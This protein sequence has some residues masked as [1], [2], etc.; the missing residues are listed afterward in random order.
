[1]LTQ[2]ASALPSPQNVNGATT[3]W[4]QC[5]LTSPSPYTTGPFIKTYVSGMQ[6]HGCV[7]NKSIWNYIWN[8][9]ICRCVKT[10]HYV[11][12]LWLS[13]TTTLRLFKSP[14]FVLLI[15]SLQDMCVLHLLP[16]IWKVLRQMSFLTMIHCC[17]VDEIICNHHQA[18][19]ELP[20]K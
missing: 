18:A 16:L 5:T 19:A 20:Q 11:E 3:L 1:M 10:L 13:V 7:L 6:G 4:E 15:K 12:L 14:L 17:Y 9:L 8:F 2:C